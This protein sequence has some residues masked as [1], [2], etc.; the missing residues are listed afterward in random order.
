MVILL[1]C[2]NKLSRMFQTIFVLN[3]RLQKNNWV[4]SVR[5]FNEG[6]SK[7]ASVQNVSMVLRKPQTGPA[8]SCDW[9]DSKWYFNYTNKQ[10]RKKTKYEL[11]LLSGQFFIKNASGQQMNYQHTLR[12]VCVW[13]ECVECASWVC[14]KHHQPARSLS[15]PVLPPCNIDAEPDPERILSPFSVE[16]LPLQPPPIITILYCNYSSLFNYLHRRLE[17][18]PLSLLIPG[19]TWAAAPGAAA[20]RSF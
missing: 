18:G 9:Y 20:E 5:V 16:R 14:V 12:W 7:G 17:C 19:E 13:V 8:Q 6:G 11:Q 10:P 4:V 3:E 2:V 15:S 1:S